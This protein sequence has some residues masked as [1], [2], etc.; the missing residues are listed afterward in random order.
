MSSPQKWLDV[1]GRK[2][3]AYYYEP[4]NVERQ[5]AFFDHFLLGKDTGLESWPRVRAEVRDSYY[6][7]TW[8]DRE[9]W[10]LEDVEYRRLHLRAGDGSLSWAPSEVEEEVGYDG[11]GSGLQPRRATFEITFPEATELVGHTTA[12][13]HVSAD[14]AEDM[15]V[16][17]ALFKLDADGRHVGFPYFAQFED[18]PVA[19]GWQ[20]ASLRELD[21]DLSTEYL[22]VLAYRRSLPITPGEPTRLDVEVL[23]S[24]TRFE[25]GEKL[26]LVVQGS[27]VMRYPEPLIYARHEQTVNHGR[28]VVHTGGR[29]DS[30][31]LVP[32][33]PAAAPG[34]PQD[35]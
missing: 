2:K 4:E 12:V 20:R 15:D 11:L 5:R 35:S 14:E 24:G 30:H 34:E 16:F 29:F 10:P 9:Q 22:P 8:R 32:V 19:V 17:V 31:L 23:P 26:L 7:G 25:A 21:E 1:H 33:L 27:D 13:L 3:W 18:G 28:N 6:Q